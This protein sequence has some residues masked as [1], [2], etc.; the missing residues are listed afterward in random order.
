[1]FKG[2]WVN[3]SLQNWTLRDPGASLSTVVT[4]L[5]RYYYLT[6]LLVINLYNTNYTFNSEPRGLHT[7]TKISSLTHRNSAKSDTYKVNPSNLHDSRIYV[8]S[9]LVM[10]PFDSILIN[11]F[12]LQ[13]SQDHIEIKLLINIFNTFKKYYIRSEEN[14]LKAYLILFTLYLLSV[15]RR[16]V[17]FFC[18]QNS[19]SSPSKN[20]ELISHQHKHFCY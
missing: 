14:V 18:S 6:L 11:L 7:N 16:N 13:S 5:L 3:V 2:I 15:Y 8:T 1:M 19:Q 10:F 17:A 4:H 20:P 9:S 12:N